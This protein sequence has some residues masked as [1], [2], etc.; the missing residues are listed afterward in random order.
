MTWLLSPLLALTLSATRLDPPALPLAPDSLQAVIYL[1]WGDGCPHCAAEKRYLENL[2]RRR[3]GIVVR[4]FEVYHDSANQ[5]LLERFAAAYGFEARAVPTTFL[6]DRH[7]V[8]FG[9]MTVFEIEALVERCLLSGCIDA[10]VRVPGFMA[11]PERAPSLLP[12][13]PPEPRP[14]R[15]DT[16]RPPP[17][18]A[19]RLDTASAPDTASVL[20]APPAPAV[21]A[22]RLRLPGFGEVPLAGRSL[23]VTTALIAFVDGFNPCS[24]WVLSV[25]LALTLQSRSRRHVVIIGLVFLTVTAA[26]YAAFIAGLF[27]VFRVVR[28]M[29]WIQVL[30][31]LVALAF[32]L[33]NVKDYFWW[34]TGPS[35]TIAAEDKPGIYRAMRRVRSAT[36]S[37]GG[38]VAA[39]VALSAGVSVVEFGCTAGFPMLWTNILTQQQTGAAVFLVL[40]LLYMLIYQL[41]EMAVFLAAVL[42]LRASRFEERHGR[43]LKLLG[44]MLMLALAGVMLVKPALM[45]DVGS[46]LVI[47]GAA[48]LATLLVIGFHRGVWTGASR[49]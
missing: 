36:G 18:A 44:G 43:A 47:F 5:G 3:P 28:F 31:A 41:D 42:T 17:S 12:L 26:V 38:L 7:W 27:T 16:A 15:A 13:P 24:L 6:A 39:T 46:A 29:G 20:T 32:G 10:G 11:P 35:L 37:L 48:F 4:Q 33:I 30:V 22:A 40:L 9:E 2:V 25:L 8:G 45:N 19:P 49:P 34:G 1:F 21:P 23:L 14:E